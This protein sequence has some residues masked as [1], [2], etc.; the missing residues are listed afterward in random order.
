MNIFVVDKITGRMYAD[1]EGK[2]HSILE[3]ASHRHQ[4]ESALMPGTKKQDQT[5]ARE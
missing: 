1:I 3:I 2:L 4:E 5:S